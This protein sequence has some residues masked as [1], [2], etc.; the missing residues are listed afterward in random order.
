MIFFIYRFN[1]M[2]NNVFHMRLNDMEND[3]FHISF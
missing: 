2:E 3:I 1:D